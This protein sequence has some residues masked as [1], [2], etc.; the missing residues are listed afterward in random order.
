MPLTMTAG[1]QSSPWPTSEQARGNIA[2]GA[3]QGDFAARGLGMWRE[4]VLI[5]A[6]GTGLLADTTLLW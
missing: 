2:K 1:L 3:Q 6:L 4:I 5:T